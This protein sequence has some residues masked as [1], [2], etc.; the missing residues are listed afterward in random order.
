MRD[1]IRASLALLLAVPSSSV[2]RAQEVERLNGPV[3]FDTYGVSELADLFI[4]SG[5]Q[6]GVYRNPDPKFVQFIEYRIQPVQLPNGSTEPF[7]A[8]YC[9]VTEPETYN[10]VWFKM[11]EADWRRYGRGELVLRL[12]Q[13]PPLGVVQVFD[14]DTD[15]RLADTDCTDTFKL[16]LKTLNAV[17]TKEEFA[18]GHQVGSREKAEQRANGYFDVKIP[19]SHFGLNQYLDRVSEFVIT[20]ENRSI[21]PSQRRGNLGLQAIVLTTARGENVDRILIEARKAR[22]QQGTNP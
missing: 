22:Q 19:L 14:P 4:K 18:L 6:F 5:V 17:G 2:A 9:N 20:F 13:L 3:V 8:V 12:R 21:A 16:E 11:G 15:Q 10:G 1:I 7:L